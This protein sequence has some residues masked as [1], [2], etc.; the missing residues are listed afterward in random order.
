MYDRRINGRE[1]TFGVSGKLIMNALVM[2][3]HQ[4]RT[5]WSQFVGQ[6]VQ[7]PLT[8]VPLGFVPVTQT[9]WLAWRDLHPDTLVLD[10]RG[11]FRGDSYSGYYSGGSAGILGETHRDR[12]LGRK[13]LI[14]GLAVADRH[15]AYPLRVLEEMPLVNDSF[16]GQ[17]TLVVFDRNTGTALAY[18]R[19]VDGSTLTFNLEE[20]S[21]GLHAIL[22]DNETGSR[23]LALTGR[24][25]EGELKG[26]TLAR[27][28]S[29][30]AFWFAW[31]DWNPDTEV[32][33]G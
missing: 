30:L 26:K 6:G 4:T 14:V 24:A 28:P 29:H 16:A 25:I 5:L 2:Y 27:A 10:K 18:L 11:R 9:T 31:K 33:E 19:Q 7:G 22:V 17:D 20:E 12:R 23:W 3:D 13:E 21:T 15:K 32:Y 8:D 1:H